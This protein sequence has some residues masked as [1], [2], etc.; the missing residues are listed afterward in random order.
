[1]SN[2]VSAKVASRWEASA[3]VAPDTDWF[4]SDIVASVDAD[5]DIRGDHRKV[6]VI[7]HL[8][9]MVPEATV[10]KIHK[11]SGGVLKIGAINEGNVLKADV[12]YQFPVYLDDDDS[13]NIQ[14]DT[15]TQN[16]SVTGREEI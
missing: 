13:Y 1:M 6:P 3:T 5:K 9:I 15:G 8:Q 7:H 11:T 14:H 10:V 2:F 12:F 4:A 16:V